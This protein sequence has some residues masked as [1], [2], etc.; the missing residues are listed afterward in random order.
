MRDL[1]VQC[2]DR[3]DRNEFQLAALTNT[4]GKSIRFVFFEIRFLFFVVPSSKVVCYKC[5][6]NLFKQLAYEFRVRMT[7]DEIHPIAL[8]QRQ[9][10]HYGRHCRTQFNK[11][12]HAQKFNHACDQTKF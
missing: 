10:C 6:L 3:L 4:A 1:L 11:L 8:R 12:A 9:N 2:C 5:G 7:P